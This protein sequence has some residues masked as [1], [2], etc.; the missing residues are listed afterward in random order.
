ME[1][2]PPN[3]T[4]V[5][6]EIAVPFLATLGYSRDGAAEAG[7]IREFSLKYDRGFLG[8][9]KSTDQPLRGRAD[10]IL[11]VP[12]AARWVLEIKGPAETIDR[13]AIEQAM[14][15][16]RHPEVAGVYAAILNGK[17]FVVFH[18][19]QPSDAEPI[20][21]LTV[22]TGID[23]AKAVE[24]FLSPAAIR[25]DCSPPRVDLLKPISKGLRSSVN[26]LRGHVEYETMEWASNIQ[27]PLPNIQALD[28]QCSRLTGYRANVV[29]GRV[30]RADSSRIIAKLQWSA[31]HPS[32]SQFANEKGLM[33]FEYVCLDEQISEDPQKP[34]VFDVF[35]HVEVK[36]GEQIFDIVRWRS[37]LIGYDTRQAIR[38]QASGHVSGNS[39]LGRFQSENKTQLVGIPIEITLFG[40]GSFEIEIDPR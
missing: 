27:L 14:S 8:R 38:G 30:W 34:S 13:D 23:L 15:Y 5:R 10:Y 21:D 1:V 28:E 31:I 2:P 17:R 37:T 6:E 35:G 4:D 3:E 11:F 25:R 18:A 7:V 12:G 9:K 36:K 33:E 22:A 26:I 29:G 39:F 24:G 40:T 19:S 20:A 16:A 32:L